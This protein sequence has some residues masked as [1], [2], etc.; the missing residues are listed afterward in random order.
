MNYSQRRRSNMHRHAHALKHTDTRSLAANIICLIHTQTH[1]FNN[2][3]AR[4]ETRRP[5]AIFR[6]Y[7]NTARF[8]SKRHAHSGAAPPSHSASVSY[9]TPHTHSDSSADTE[10]PR[11]H[12]GRSPYP[13]YSAYC[14]QLSAG[15]QHPRHAR[16]PAP[17][18]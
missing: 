4:P 3:R 17:C 18:K 10:N 2:D 8:S 13:S 15:C 11:V 14:V 7:I 16:G 1:V 12:R 5:F 9:L 6:A